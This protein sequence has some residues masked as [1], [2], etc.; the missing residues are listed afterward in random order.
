MF[1]R[2]E[3]R[4]D[5]SGV[6]VWMFVSWMCRNPLCVLSSV[7]LLRERISCNINSISVISHTATVALFIEFMNAI[8]CVARCVALTAH[9]I[10][11][12]MLCSP[13]RR[14]PYGNM[15][16]WGLELSQEWE[17]VLKTPGGGMLSQHGL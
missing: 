15:F 9:A 11:Q 1:G 7:L 10:K 6:T 13:A 4:W 8:K 3:N 2:N 5:T 14:A 12:L 16:G 17:Q